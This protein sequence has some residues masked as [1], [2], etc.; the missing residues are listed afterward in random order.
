MEERLYSGALL[1]QDDNNRINHSNKHS[2]KRST[3]PTNIPNKPYQTVQGEEFT[4]KSFN[5]SND[6]FTRWGIPKGCRLRGG[7][8]SSLAGSATGG[9]GNSNNNNANTAAWTASSGNNGQQQPPSSTNP[10]QAQQ[11]SQWA[12]SNNNNPT[13]SQRPSTNATSPQSQQNTGV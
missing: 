3:T 4:R 7:G 10:T 11:P 13:P 6:Y 9:W 2:V 5:Y 1:L 12:N 8:E